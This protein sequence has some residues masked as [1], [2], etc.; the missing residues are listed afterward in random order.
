VKTEPITVWPALGIEVSAD[1]KRTWAARAAQHEGRVVVELLDPVP[2]T[3]EVLDKIP[4]WRT[5]WQITAIGIDPRSPSATL[6]A[7]LKSMPLALAD[8]AG[9]AVAHGRFQDLLAADRLR[10]RGHDALDQAARQA[11]ERRLAGSHAVDRYQGVDP[12]PLVAA[13]LAVWALL[14]APKPPVP[15][16]MF[17]K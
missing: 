7:P 12:A 16:V 9:M 1:R 3:A 14:D 4:G 17:G 5:D 13:E 6:V 11:E 15:F 2:G 10:I 8:A